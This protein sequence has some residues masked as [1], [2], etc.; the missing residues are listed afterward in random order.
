[1]SVAKR[2]AQFKVTP[3]YITCTFIKVYPNTGAPPSE[4]LFRGDIM[5]D[6]PT[7]ETAI[8]FMGQTNWEQRHKLPCSVGS[9][10]GNG[11]TLRPLGGGW[12][13][14][15]AHDNGVWIDATFTASLASALTTFVQLNAML[16][17]I[18]GAA[19]T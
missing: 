18:S 10:E 19:Q 3:S 12:I 13:F 15:T 14:E 16:S 9:I 6:V 7:A 4:T 8:R 5:L 1:M 11:A 17:G 2:E